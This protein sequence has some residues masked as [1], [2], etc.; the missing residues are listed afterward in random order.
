ML[1]NHTMEHCE[2]VRV[3]V[4]G[5]LT[6]SLLPPFENLYYSCDSGSHH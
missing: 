1:V 3:G 6:V 2:W 4:E 5:I